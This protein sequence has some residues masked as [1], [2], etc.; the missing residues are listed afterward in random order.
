MT[1]CYT[2]I[3]DIRYVAPALAF[4]RSLRSVSGDRLRIYTLDAEAAAVAR[5]FALERVEV[6]AP[7]EYIPPDVEQLRQS[8]SLS[9]FAFTLKPI[10][11]LHASSTGADWISYFDTDIFVFTDPARL[12]E[13]LPPDAPASFTPHRFS[14]AFRYYE[15]SV[16]RFNAGYVAFR[17]GPEGRKILEDWRDRCVAWCQDFVEGNRYSDQKYLD[18]L[19]DIYPSID[20][21]RHKGANVAPWNISGM[22][23]SLEEEQVCVDGDPLVFYHFQGLKIY[24]PRLFDLYASG[25]LIVDG[26]LLDL[27]Y[28]PYV[29]LLDQAY[30]DVT[31]VNRRAV[32]YAANPWTRTLA[33]FGWRQPGNLYRIDTSRA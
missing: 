31:Q 23:L 22:R 17:N 12:L 26:P 5:R 6:F 20:I 3:C 32:E 18:E 27:V 8:R 29:R 14:P 13:G 9:A 10:V 25:E 21:C 4:Y 7:E 2:L 16:G 28:R 19:S 30:D 24:G 1:I 33:R 11:L 15:A